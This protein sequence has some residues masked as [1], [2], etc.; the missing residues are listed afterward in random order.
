M[1]FLLAALSRPPSTVE[2]VRVA[3]KSVTLRIGAPS[4]GRELS[5]TGYRVRL[6]TTRGSR[7]MDIRDVDVGRYR[8]HRAEF[9]D[10][11]KCRCR[12]KCACSEMVTKI[13]KTGGGGWHKVSR[14]W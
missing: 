4:N 10:D 8:G 2:V 6:A 13:F 3:E 11:L 12:Q 9:A 1:C 14:I 7:P 5:V